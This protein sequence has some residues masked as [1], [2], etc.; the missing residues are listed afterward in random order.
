M[1]TLLQTFA[2]IALGCCTVPV[3]V[4]AQGKPVVLQNRTELFVDDYLV[5]KLERMEPRL[6]I[7]VSAGKALEFDR[8]WEGQ[9]SIA[10]TV[11]KTAGVYRMFYRGLGKTGGLD[12]THCYA[13]SDDGIHWRRPELGRVKL[14][15]WPKN[16]VIA[17]AAG[18]KDAEQ[19]NRR[20]SPNL[21]LDDRPGVP[22]DERYKAVT[23]IGV[24]RGHG[25]RIIV[26]KDG[27]TWRPLDPKAAPIAVGYALD[28]AN[29]IT[30]V[31]AENCYAI[32]MRGWT[33]DKPGVT[34][35]TPNEFGRISPFFHG[36][37]TFMRSVSTDLVNWTKP[38]IM[39]F[40]DTPLEHFYTNST[41]PY[42]RAPH[43]LIAMPMRFD[44]ELGSSV[45]TEAEFKESGIHPKMWKGVSDAVFMTSRGGNSFHRQFLEAVIRPGPDARNWGA[46]SQIVALGVVPTGPAEMSFYVNRAYATQGAFVERMTLRT[47]GFVSLQA[48]Y[49]PGTAVT[50]PL[51]LRGSTFLLNFAS[52]PFGYVKV[53]LLDEAGRELP[54]FGEADAEV[55]RGD[56]VDRKVQWK[57]GRT[58]ADLGQQNI[59]IKFIAKDADI[60]S[61]GIYDSDRHP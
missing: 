22:E 48:G 41:Q 57:S 10:L 25:M 54:G 40:G 17:H 39:T 34:P 53:V 15:S 5:E 2:F 23:S 28:S 50:R 38:E 31:P 18:P 27:L 59:R 55:I 61:F 37:R 16:N 33:G 60:Y 58:I 24:G 20:G 7:P 43:I 49:Q 1:K 47:D 4:F 19:F 8:P 30:W 12:E 35:D 44:P 26:S 3:A 6:G 9:F 11:I 56:R 36:V 42:F 46:R 29:I 21:L 13:E 45:L 14:P 32:Y 52:S 51:V